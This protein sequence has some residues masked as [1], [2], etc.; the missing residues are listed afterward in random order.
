MV[1]IHNTIIR[2]L[3]S[4]YKQA[5]NLSPSDYKP[6]IGFSMTWYK[7]VHHHHLNE[8]EHFFKGLDASFGPEVMNESLEEHHAF[9]EG[10][11]MFGL[12]LTR[13]TYAQRN[14]CYNGFASIQG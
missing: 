13:S 6:F 14:W 3:N 2:G 10:L 11:E 12:Y 1:C 9:Y 7:I 5:P 8:E 4:M